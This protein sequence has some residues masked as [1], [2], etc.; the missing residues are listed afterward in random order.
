MITD[1]LQCLINNG[2]IEFHTEAKYVNGN[3]TF[4]MILDKVNEDYIQT[5]PSRAK[6]DESITAVPVPKTT[7]EFKSAWGM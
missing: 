6:R 7:E 4:Y 1:V 2:L 3:K 5:I